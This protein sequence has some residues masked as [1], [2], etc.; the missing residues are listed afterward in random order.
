MLALGHSSPGTPTIL[1]ERH[2]CGQKKKSYNTCS[3]IS[4]I[5][6]MCLDFQMEQCTV[7]TNTVKVTDGIINAN[8]VQ[9]DVNS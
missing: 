3:L 4:R 5:E 8:N 9:V 6:L 2:N 1:M 7:N